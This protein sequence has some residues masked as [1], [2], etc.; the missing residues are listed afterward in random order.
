M[1]STGINI[2]TAAEDLVITHEEAK[3]VI[4]ETFKSAVVGGILVYMILAFGK[5]IGLGKKE[6]IKFVEMAKKL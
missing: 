4:I 1:T 3:S 2:L 5:G 6:E